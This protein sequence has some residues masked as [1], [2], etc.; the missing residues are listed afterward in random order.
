MNISA[1][2]NRI[3]ASRADPASRALRQQ[4]D[5]FRELLK[6]KKMKDG[7]GLGETG[8]FGFGPPPPGFWKSVGDSISGAASTAYRAVVGYQPRYMRPDLNKTFRPKSG[9]G[10]PVYAA[11]EQGYAA[12]E[13]IYPYVL[14]AVVVVT[15]AGAGGYVGHRLYRWYND[16]AYQLVQS[17]YPAEVLPPIRR[18]SV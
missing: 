2:N 18:A 7:V 10:E 8:G 14:P 5:A 4:E 6:P 12:G 17:P 11:G 9:G 3:A 16:P 13:A 1:S 15:F